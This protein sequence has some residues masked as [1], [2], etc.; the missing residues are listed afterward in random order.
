MSMYI[1]WSAQGSSLG[2]ATVV[3]CQNMDNMTEDEIL[4]AVRMTAR[5]RGRRPL[6]KPE[7]ARMML[8]VF[9]TL[10]IRQVSGSR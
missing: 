10:L 8:D 9:R 6:S 5:P 2:L 3:E 1:T 7:L 4:A